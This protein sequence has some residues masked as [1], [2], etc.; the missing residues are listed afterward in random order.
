MKK[1]DRQKLH[2]EFGIHFKDSPDELRF[3]EEFIDEQEKAVREEVAD[4]IRKYMLA[5]GWKINLEQMEDVFTFIR[6]EG[7]AKKK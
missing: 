1:E 5:R 4:M 3:L 7:Q 2:N 6:K